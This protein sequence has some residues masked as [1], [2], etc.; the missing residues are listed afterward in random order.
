MEDIKPQKALKISV[1]I[2]FNAGKKMER[3]FP[4]LY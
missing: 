1:V 4:I 2:F 3:L